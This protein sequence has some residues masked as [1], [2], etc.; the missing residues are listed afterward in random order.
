MF[1]KFAKSFLAVSML[2]A[3][4]APA[5]VEASTNEDVMKTVLTELEIKFMEEDGALVLGTENGII[6][7]K[8]DSKNDTINI[9]GISRLGISQINRAKAYRIINKLNQDYAVKFYLDDDG[10][11]ISQVVFD[12]NDMTISK[13]AAAANLVRVVKGLEF[14]EEALKGL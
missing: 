3:L 1:K 6:V 2:F 10:D 9:A 11:L 14:A 7:I 8:V 13:T 12:T 5:T 4:S